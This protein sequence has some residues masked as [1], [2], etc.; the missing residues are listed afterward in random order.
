MAASMRRAGFALE[1]VRE[2][3][4][5]ESLVT[6]QRYLALLLDEQDERGEKIAAFFGFS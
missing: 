6:T 3:L 5:H 4:A 2:A 1:E